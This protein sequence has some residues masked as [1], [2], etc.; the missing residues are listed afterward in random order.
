MQLIIISG[1]SGSG[2][3]RLS[4]KILKKLN[5][6]II[7]NTDNYYYTGIISKIFAK[8]ITSYFDRKISFNFKLFK[9]DLD[10]ILKNG[11][12]NFSYKYNFEKKTKKKIY[13]KTKNI[14]HIIIEG[15]FVSEIFQFLSSKNLIL[16]K[17]K[18]NKNTCMKRVVKRDFVK[19]GKSK[20]LAKRDFIKAWDLF[21][22]DRK[23]ENSNIYKKIIIIRNK[24]DINFLLK[25]ITNIVN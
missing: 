8:L 19:R 9:R 11:F 10:Y 14:K 16:I 7:I 12:S 15:I 5:N 17:L 24:N 25:K 20:N 2:K 4:K 21:Y 6:G 1:P 22:K 13:K 18:T 3:T 23:K